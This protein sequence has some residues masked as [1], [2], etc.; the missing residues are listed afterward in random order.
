[1]S[2]LARRVPENYQAKTTEVHIFE[3]RLCDDLAV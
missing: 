3:I 2:A 1:M